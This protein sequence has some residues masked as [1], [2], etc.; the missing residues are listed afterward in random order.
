MNWFVTRTTS[1]LA[2]GAVVTMVAAIFVL[3]P[4]STDIIR[5]AGREELLP[6]GPWYALPLVGVAFSATGFVVHQR[7]PHLVGWVLHCVGL[8][9][10]GFL[11]GGFLYSLHAT[12]WWTLNTLGKMVA[13]WSQFGWMV[14]VVLMTTFLPLLFP[15]GRPPSPRWRCVVWVGAA[16]LALGFVVTTVDVFVRPFEEVFEEPSASLAE[17]VVFGLMILGAL[18]AASSVAVRYRRAG[19]IERH[20]LKWVAAALVMVVVAVSPALTPLGRVMGRS[21]LLQLLLAVV[22]CSIPISIGIAITRYH[23]YEI[24]RII[25][26]TVSYGL[27]TA[28]LATVYIGAVFGFQQG[29]RPI[30]GESALSVAGATLVVA[31][32]FRPVRGRVQ[33]LVDRRFN[34][35][36]YDAQRA[37]EAFQLRMRDE[38][39]L[40]RIGFELISV[41]RTTVEPSVV[42]LW[43]HAN[44]DDKR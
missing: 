31:A 30:T 42:F 12:G 1:A 37:V 21:D 14:A 33:W 15:S 18:G 5:E 40:D 39:D 24:D 34:R 9:W 16:S 23:L 3:Y 17:T 28:V 19:G 2:L 25:S 44:R 11:L 41:V 35:A 26:R 13:A 8:F 20:Q 29:L 4:F 22:M 27:V 10:S 38:V 43:L 7:E 6:S 32:L 36:R